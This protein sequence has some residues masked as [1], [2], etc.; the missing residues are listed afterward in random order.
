MFK[1]I[2][3]SL[4]LLLPFSLLFSQAGYGVYQFLDLPVSSRQAALGGSNISSRDHDLSFAFQNPSVLTDRT[5]KMISLNIANYLSDINFGSAMYGFSLGNK[6]YLALGVQFI[7]YGSFV[8]TNDVNVD[9]G[10][11]GAQ[12]MALNIVYTRPLTDQISVG[13]TLK[14]IFSVFE[15]YTSFGIAMD[16]G[17]S[18][19]HPKQLFTAGFVLRNIGSQIT[20]YYSN[21][22]GQHYEPLP[23]NVQ[24]G[25][26]H[27]LEHGPLRFSLTLHN[28]QRWNLDYSSLN[29]SPS[30]GSLGFDSSDNSNSGKPSSFVDKAFRHAI[31][32]VEFLPGKNFY[33]AASY[34]HR[35]HQELRMSGFK[36]LAGFSFGGGLKLSK[37]QLGFGMSQFQVGN[38]SYQ[39]SINTSL[40]EF[41]L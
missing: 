24:L 33:L 8:K 31:I 7:D 16:A 4:L 3:F 37:F 12:D 39:F 6:N 10:E 18:Y 5:A 41:G 29:Q 35:R 23:F 17:V 32:G 36:S 30:S 27:K 13:A 40:A 20:G 1:K 28:L 38:Y 14:P 21:E 2:V 26:S 15:S 25:L 19:V 22:N 11:F 9:E 34:H